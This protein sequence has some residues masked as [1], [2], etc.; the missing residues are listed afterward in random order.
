MNL[1]LN[2]V[3]A[4]EDLEVQRRIVFLVVEDLEDHVEVAV[5]DLGDGVDEEELALIREAFFTKKRGGSGLGLAIAERVI[6]AHGGDLTLNNLEG[7]GF[8]ARVSLPV[9]TDDGNMSQPTA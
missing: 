5:R 9:S 4:V 8:E 1:V 2:A 7:Q 3:Q 6:G